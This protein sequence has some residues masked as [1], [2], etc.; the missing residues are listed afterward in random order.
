MHDFPML[1]PYIEKYQ[2]PYDLNSNA[3]I[4]QILNSQLADQDS[5]LKSLAM[6]LEKNKVK[7]KKFIIY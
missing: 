6:Y 3:Y 2:L 4:E 5:R 1:F 7:R